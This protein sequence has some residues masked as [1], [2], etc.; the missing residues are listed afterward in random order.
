M[1]LAADIGYAGC[2]QT[3]F[4]SDAMALQAASSV[5]FLPVL[6][7]P[8]SGK[9]SGRCRDSVMFFRWLSDNSRKVGSAAMVARMSWCK[10]I[11]YSFMNVRLANITH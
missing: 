4:S 2:M 10:S 9:V 11:E 6:Y 8:K 7:A 1:K 3:L 5:G